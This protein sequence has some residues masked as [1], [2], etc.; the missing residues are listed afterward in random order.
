MTI[1]S[2][3]L[4]AIPLAALAFPLAAIA[5]ASDSRDDKAAKSQKLT[6]WY[7][8]PAKLWMQEALPI[9]N[10]RIGAMVFGGVE[11]ERIQFN[12]ISLWTGTETS[13]DEGSYQAFGDVHIS[14]PAQ[15]ESSDY[16]R[17]LDI[18]NALS[19][20]SYRS[21]GVFYRR[22]Y[23]ASYPDQVILGRF[24]ADKPGSYTGS[25][26]LT[27]MHGE[28]VTAS[29]DLLTFHGKLENGQRYET[30]VRVLHDGGTL[31]VSGGKLTFDGCNSLTIILAAGTDYIADRSRGW[32]G[33]DPHERVSGQIAAAS[34]KE[35]D[36]IRAD[37]E[38]DYHALFNRVAID[39]GA[40]PAGQAALPTDKRLVT[41]EENNTD[42]ELNA[43]YFQFGRY[44]LISS[45][46]PGTLP[47]NLQ[48]L[49]NDINNPPWNSDYHT[50]INIQM[51]YWPAEVTNLSECH[52]PMLD[53]VVEGA[54]AWRDATSREPEFKVEGRPLR[55]WTVR[56]ESNI[57][58]NTTWNWNKSANA[59]YCQHFW[60]HYAFTGDR[61]FL[62]DIAYPMLKETVEF[63]EDQLKTLPDGSLV[64]P[65]GWSPEH[66][67]TED[68]VSYDQEIIWDL[69]TNYIEAADTL[70]IDPEYRE[71]VADMRRKLLTPKIG[72]WGQLQEWVEDIDD[73]NDQHRHV[74]HL[75][76]LYPGRQI[77]PSTTP[78]LA[79]AAKKSLEARGDGG[80]G[81][82]R[83]WKI[84][85]WAR[86][87]DGDHAYL[88][89]RNLLHPVTTVET[90]YMSGGGTYVNLFDAHPP[91][92]IDGNFGATAAIA[93][94]LLQSQNG[95]IHLLPALPAA[96]PEG[97]VTGL[98][99]RGGFTVDIRWSK[100]KLVLAKIHAEI[101]KIC[102]IRY[103][104]PVRLGGMIE[105]LR[106]EPHV[107]Q[108]TAKAGESYE[109]DRE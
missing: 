35:Y 96:W 32:K 89:L 36:K 48:G 44:L 5:T 109:V 79:A 62:K 51:N 86:F 55:G 87:H 25:I 92:Q 69:F 102:R 64:A 82:S 12:E 67:P 95:E 20:V 56:T 108:W 71:R 40:S 18:A 57:Y 85:Y 61:A 104:E 27:G 91:F 72:K 53:F 2:S 7:D 98:R 88:L 29:G 1:L 78:E 23:F 37:H 84:A 10:G 6:L 94:M 97:S 22:E 66:G 99:A 74:S 21:N 76:A 31:A 68:G 58:G 34:K 8:R 4:A 107:M 16:R 50:N 90:D 59:W 13:E 93:E 9:G 41:Y 42:P 83:A 70:N 73:P 24:T 38:R 19:T 106:P 75:F 101:A 33:E 46:R 65:Q 63:W 81:W 17:T 39:L 11:Q 43:L 15:A 103:T 49:W 28:T 80:T 45:S 30:Q 100:G 47:A 52:L 3:L 26:D 77:S 54:K 105:I 14:F 60:E